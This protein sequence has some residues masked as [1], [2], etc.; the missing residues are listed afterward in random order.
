MLHEGGGSTTLTA[1]R[2]VLDYDFKAINFILEHICQS[3]D[4]ENYTYKLFDEDFV[5]SGPTIFTGE[6]SAEIN[7]SWMSL[8]ARSAE[9]FKGEAEMEQSAIK[10]RSKFA[11]D[12]QRKKIMSYNDVMSCF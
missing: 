8:R 5:D 12:I 9:K 4:H 10:I 3:S 1:L 7:A 2:K 11:V 6:F